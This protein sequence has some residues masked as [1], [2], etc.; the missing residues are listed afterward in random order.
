MP[1]GRANPFLIFV[2]AP[3]LRLAT[4]FFR[5]DAPWIDV[6]MGA[7]AA[8]WSS[9]MICRPDIFDQGSF[10]GMSWLPDLVWIGF[11]LLL[12]AAHLVGLFRLGWRTWRMLTALGSSWMWLCV[13]TSFLRVDIGTGVCTY[14][15]FGGIALLGGIYVGVQPRRVR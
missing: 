10:V 7:L 5:H 9:L 6:V 11:T 3:V 2:V 1:L 12:A 13:A 8:A 14:A 15:I 4:W